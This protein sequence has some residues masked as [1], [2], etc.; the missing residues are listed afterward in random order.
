MELIKTGY[1]IKGLHGEEDEKC[2]EC[3]WIILWQP[4]R[5]GTNGG[6]SERRDFSAG[7]EVQGVSEQLQGGDVS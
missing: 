4:E 6:C 2:S 5:V 7:C 3:K 1:W